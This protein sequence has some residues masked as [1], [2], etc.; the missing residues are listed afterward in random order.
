MCSC[1]HVIVPLEESF[2]MWIPSSYLC[3]VP[4][5]YICMSRVHGGVLEGRL[6]QGARGARLP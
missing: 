2:S 6:G 4:Y 3:F 5:I 1:V